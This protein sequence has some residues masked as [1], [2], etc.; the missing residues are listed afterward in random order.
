M[1]QKKLLES[2][3]K[4]AVASS[5]LVFAALSGIYNIFVSLIYLIIMVNGMSY[6]NKDLLPWYTTCTH[7]SKSAALATH[8][9][10]I[11]VPQYW[12]LVS[13]HLSI[14]TSVSIPYCTHFKNLLAP[15]P[16]HY[17]LFPVASFSWQWL[18]T[19]VV[20]KVPQFISWYLGVMIYRP[21]H[22]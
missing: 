12:H 21:F 14:P 3:K 6:N 17:H 15:S 10:C 2:I 22:N 4:N 11:S 16:L 5:L 19:I 18:S 7:W 20:E 8:V 13:E 1:Q 9:T